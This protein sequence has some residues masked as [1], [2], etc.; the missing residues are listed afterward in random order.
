M[1]ITQTQKLQPGFGHG[2]LLILISA[3]LSLVVGSFGLLLNKFIPGFKPWNMLFS[4]V[5][6]FGI[7][8]IAATRIWQSKTI[9]TTKTGTLLFIILIPATIGMSIISES[10]VSLIPMPEVIAEWFAKMIQFDLAGY[11]T[12]GIAAPILE[13]LIFRGV[14]LKG[15]LKKFNPTKAILFSAL[16]FGIA[17]LNPWQFIAA[18]MAGI[19]IGWVYYKTR[20]IWAAIFIHFINNSFSFYIGYNYNDINTTFYEISGGFLNY[21]ILIT[22]SILVCYMVYLWINKSFIN[23]QT[24]ETSIQI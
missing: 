1:D 21:L 4:F 13:E 16:L 6:T 17:H 15:F 20:S 5:L 14:V 7:T 19:V 18:F 8:F 11:L 2:L 10:I 22:G 24:R 23:K 12:V 3:L 9:E